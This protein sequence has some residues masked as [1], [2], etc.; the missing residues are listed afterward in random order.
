M[1]NSIARD[2]VPRQRTK[3]KLRLL[4]RPDDDPFFDAGYIP[5][6]PEDPDRRAY[7]PTTES[8]IYPDEPITGSGV[9]T[10]KG[11][12]TPRGATHKPGKLTPRATRF[13]SAVHQYGEDFNELSLK[14]QIVASEVS[15]KMEMYGARK[16]AEQAGYIS[17]EKQGQKTLV[18]LTD[19]PLPSDLPSIL[20]RQ[21]RERCKEVDGM[22]SSGDRRDRYGAFQARRREQVPLVHIALAHYVPYAFPW[23]DVDARHMLTLCGDSLEELL[24]QLEHIAFYARNDSKGGKRR[25]KNPKSF[26]MNSLKNNATDGG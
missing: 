8:V 22:D 9:G 24:T 26:V 17:T 21:L 10:P 14:Q 3:P 16:E 2:G 23:S 11:V 7:E 19:K 18:Y 15:D 4:D 20:L 6:D 1:K 13:L 25:L 5:E 12:G